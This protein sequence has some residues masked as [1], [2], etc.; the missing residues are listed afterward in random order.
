MEVEPSTRQRQRAQCY[1]KHWARGRR[2]ITVVLEGIPVARFLVS[3]CEVR[4]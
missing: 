2:F 1:S 3:T 4:I